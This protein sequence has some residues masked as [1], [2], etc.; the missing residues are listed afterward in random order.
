MIAAGQI[1]SGGGS[2]SA[3]R[4]VTHWGDT[5]TEADYQNLT[6]RWITT[7]LAEA[8]GLRRVDSSTGREMF[9]RRSGDLAGIIIP[10]IAPWDSNHIREYRERLDKPDLECASDGGLREKNKYI[11]PPGRTNLIYFPPGLP[12]ATLEDIAIPIIITEGEF[13]SLALWRLANHN[14]QSFGSCRSHLRESGTG[15]V[16]SLRSRDQMAIAGM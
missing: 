8:A 14:H 12:S 11:Q 3:P 10:N 7:A 4:I 9:S 16:Q 1:A 5:L 2:L 6:A 15:K 13:K